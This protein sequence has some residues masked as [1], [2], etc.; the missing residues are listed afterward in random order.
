MSTSGTRLDKKVA[1]VVSAGDHMGMTVSRRLAEEGAKIAALDPDRTG[2]EQA[3]REVRELGGEVL[4]LV[5]DVVRPADVAEAIEKAVARFARV[6]I[7]VN[8][9][10]RHGF[11]LI[12]D[13]SEDVKE[14]EIGANLKATY[15][16]I[17]AVAAH[18]K[19]QRYGRIVNISS[20]AKDGV[21]WI[22]HRGH[23]V[24]AATRGGVSV[25]TRA[26]AFELGRYNVTVN[27]VVPGP[28]RHPRT[29]K[30]FSALRDDP[31]VEALSTSMMALKCLGTTHDVAN[32]VLFL[33]SDEAE[34]ITGNALYVSGGLYG[35]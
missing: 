35:G 2:V 29:E 13:V 16:A 25:L 22:A 21:P 31:E 8:T 23:S 30:L 11:R 5:V 26:L 33:A 32:A 34:Y 24:H 28:L 9:V 15:A 6:D 12:E 14:E 10:M 20:A 19:R 27:S 17:R 3:E 18:M 7:L 1:V 4:A